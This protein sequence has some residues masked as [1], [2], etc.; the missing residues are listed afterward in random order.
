MLTKLNS[1]SGTAVYSAN[2]LEA[3]IVSYEDDD[4]GIALLK[5]ETIDRML[6]SMVGIPVIINH[7]K[8]TPENVGKIS[9]GRVTRVWFNP[10]DAWFWCEFMVTEPEAIKRID[11]DGDSVSCAFNVLDIEEGGEWHNIKFDAEITDGAFTHLALVESPRYED[12]QIIKQFPAMLVNGKSA[13]FQTTTPE[14]ENDNMFNIFKKKENSKEDFS[15]LH[16]E[17]EGQEVPLSDILTSYQNSKKKETEEKKNAKVLAKDEDVVEIGGEKVSVADLKTSFLNSKK[18]KEQLEKEK[19]N[20]KKNSDEDDEKKKKE[21][22]EKKNEK[23]KEE[24]ETKEKEN[25][26]KLKEEQEKLNAK[27]VGDTF[28]AE[29][30]NASKTGNEEVASPAPRTRQERANAFREKNSKIKKS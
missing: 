8:V 3:G 30:E 24:K 9:K 21:E 13:R 22:E 10:D 4:A 23:E 14:Q 17:I 7:K 2:F 16:V 27:K 11:E 19:L 5:K 29:L 26:K 18:S 12:A 6:P 28:F 20:E 15:N 25:A 1:K